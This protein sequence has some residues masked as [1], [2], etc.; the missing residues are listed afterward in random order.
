MW[1]HL[2]R[3][4]EK[5]E[6]DH[7]WELD[8]LLRCCTERHSFND[9]TCV[10]IRTL[11]PFSAISLSQKQM[12]QLDCDISFLTIARPLLFVGASLLLTCFALLSKTILTLTC[13]IRLTSNYG[14]LQFNPFTPS[15][16]PCR[17]TRNLPWPSE[18]PLINNTDNVVW[19]MIILP[20]LTTSLI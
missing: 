17:L 13:K 12:G 15:K 11:F 18:D 3:L 14:I 2:V 6:I 16:F 20:I 19:E 8:K 1:Y 10:L 9:A 4:Q 5:L 7:S